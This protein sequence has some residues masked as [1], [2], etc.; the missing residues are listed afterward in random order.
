MNIDQEITKIVQEKLPSIAAK[1]ILN[2]LTEGQNAVT[3]RNSMAERI[4]ELEK[5]NEEQKKRIK[6]LESEY[7]R[8]TNELL[9]FD[10]KSKAFE[11]EKIAFDLRKAKFEGYEEAKRKDNQELLSVVQAVFANNKYKYTTF[12]N[13][14]ISCDGGY[15]S[16]HPFDSNT[17]VEG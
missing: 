3:E 4:K 1:E 16:N 12:G 15:P 8:H 13:K 9:D 2:A 17:E 7:A 5:E 14:P 11:E 6:E 10:S